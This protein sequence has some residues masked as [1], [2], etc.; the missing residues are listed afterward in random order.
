[1]AGDMV[2]KEKSDGTKVKVLG[3]TYEAGRP[4]SPLHWKNRF[5]SRTEYMNYLKQAERY[6][7]NKDWYGSEKRRNPA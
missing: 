7:Y 1:M 5:E 6:W 2:E 4:E 3:E